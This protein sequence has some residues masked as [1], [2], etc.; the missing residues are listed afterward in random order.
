MVA[1]ARER[2]EPTQDDDVPAEV[3]AFRAEYRAKE[4]GPR[5]RGWLHFAFTTFGSLSV[6]AFAATRVHG[7]SLAEWATVPLAFLFANLAE[8]LAHKGPM[9]RPLAGMKILF[10]RHTRQHHH[11]FTHDAMAYASSRDFKMVLF[12]PFVVF[13]FLGVIA[14]P[15]ALLLG[16]LVSPNVGWLFVVTGM[17]YFL[18]YEWLHFAYHLDPSSAVGGHPLLR[19]L[20]ALHRTH[21]DKRLM[22]KWNFNITFPICDLLFGTWYAPP[23]TGRGA[24]ARSVEGARRGGPPRP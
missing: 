2:V 14:A 13:F 17:G 20:R 22:G 21:H 9:H 15:T 8:Y 11:F 18:T 12:P 10:R 4:I 16:A 1:I 23:S 7:A 19:R 24:T 3:R 6:I 5:Y